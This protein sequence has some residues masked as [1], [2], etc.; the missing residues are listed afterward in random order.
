MR[1]KVGPRKLW[2]VITTYSYICGMAVARSGKKVSPVPRDKALDAYTGQWVAIKDGV[3]VAHGRSSRDVV[4]Q[5]HKMGAAGKGAVLHR[6]ASPD[7][8]LAV[9]LG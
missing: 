7:E 4:R 6:A 8:P 2:R 1:L 3:V 5:L 9:G